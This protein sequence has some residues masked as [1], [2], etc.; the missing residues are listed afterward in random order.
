MRLR[1]LK[2]TELDDYVTEVKFLRALYRRI[3]WKP[4]LDLCTNPI[5]SNALAPLFF[6]AMCDALK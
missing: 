2:H 4:A 3:K 6:S 1:G 5:G